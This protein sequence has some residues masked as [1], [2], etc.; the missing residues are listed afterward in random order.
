[1]CK[2]SLHKIFYSAYTKGISFTVTSDSDI[3][4]LAYILDSRRLITRSAVPLQAS[5]KDPS[6]FPELPPHA[7]RDLDS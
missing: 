3:E 6:A 7:T 4:H 5:Y 2:W 1:M